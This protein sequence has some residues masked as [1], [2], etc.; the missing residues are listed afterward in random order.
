[1]DKYNYRYKFEEVQEIFKNHGYIPLFSEYKT[2]KVKLLCQFKEN[3]YKGFICLNSL[4]SGQS[5]AWFHYTN[6]YTID[7]I[8]QYIINNKIDC[9]LLT[10]QWV[11]SVDKLLFKCKRC[12]NEFE[13]CW[14]E[15]GKGRTKS[16]YNC[17][18]NESVEKKRNDIDVVKQ[19]FI[20]RGYTPLFDDYK[21]NKQGLLVKDSLGYKGII[22]YHAFQ[23]NN[24]FDKF[25]PQ[26]PYTIENIK[27]YININNLKCSYKF[28]EYKNNNSL[29]TFECECGEYFTTS[30]VVFSHLNKTR[31]DICSKK[32]SIMELKIQKWLDFGAV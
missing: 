26:N 24:G 1:M 3:G 2:N 31:C 5:I 10:S 29:L 20:D 15:F 8:K 13:M 9:E 22:S 23:Q 27:H 30:W 16:C 4:L 11:S 28:G 21:E 17:F 14:A 25:H 32:K 6:P 18:V 7:N 12:G 19:A